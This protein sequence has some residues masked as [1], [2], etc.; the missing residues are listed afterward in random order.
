M[1]RIQT[2]LRL[3]FITLV[4]PVIEGQWVHIVKS[5]RAVLTDGPTNKTECVKVEDQ[6]WP[7]EVR[8]RS[9]P[10]IN[11]IPA[12]L[13]VLLI[14]FAPSFSEKQNIFLSCSFPTKEEISIYFTTFLLSSIFLTFLLFSW[15]RIC[16]KNW[17]KLKV[18]EDRDY[19]AK[20]Q[21]WKEEDRKKKELK[22]K[23]QGWKSFL[24]KG[25][26]ASLAR[27]N[28]LV[29]VTLSPLCRKLSHPC[30]GSSFTLVEVAHSPL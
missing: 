23:W 16:Q 2:H 11:A 3:N 8:L 1:Q 18:R 19:L 14:I 25:E 27:V 28:E 30:A 17:P 22:E 26:R 29:N 9:H 15:P 4:H 24:S 12:F 5:V 13:A 7:K 6:K 21:K 10:W 20:Q